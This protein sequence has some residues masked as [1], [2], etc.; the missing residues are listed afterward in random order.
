MELRLVSMYLF[1]VKSQL[2]SFI[3]KQF[4]LA[5]EL[6]NIMRCLCFLIAIAWESFKTRVNRLLLGKRTSNASLSSIKTSKSTHK[7]CYYSEM[8]L[9]TQFYFSAKPSIQFTCS[10]EL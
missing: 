5:V 2:C 7:K 10:Y 9:I 6:D 3:D 1:L 8:C 4:C